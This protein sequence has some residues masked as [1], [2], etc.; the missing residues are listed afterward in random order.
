[1]QKREKAESLQV[2]LDVGRPDI[3]HL[4]LESASL[5]GQ[6]NLAPVVVGHRKTGKSDQLI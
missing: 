3:V 1:V 5:V 2:G 4:Q 6:V